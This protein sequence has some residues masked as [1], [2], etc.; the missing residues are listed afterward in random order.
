MGSLIK[1][2]ALAAAFVVGVSAPAL[3]ATCTEPVPPVIAVNGVTATVQQMKD[4]IGDFKNYQSAADDFQSCISVE[5][6][7]KEAAAKKSSS[8]KPIDP[9]ILS[10]LNSR[11][12]AVQAEKE[13]LGGQ[14]NAQIVAFKQAHPGQ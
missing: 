11:A 10:A 14:L 5:I 2:T 8:H 1:R 7:K 9:A 13:K 4:A 12:N 3:A 6:Q